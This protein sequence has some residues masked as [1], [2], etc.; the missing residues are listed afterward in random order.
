MNKLTME[1]IFM[2][3]HIIQIVQTMKLYL[4]DLRITLGTAYYIIF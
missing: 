4:M 3:Y 1:D 2:F